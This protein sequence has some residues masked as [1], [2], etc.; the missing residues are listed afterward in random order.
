MALKQWVL[1]PAVASPGGSPGF[2]PWD[3]I[4]TFLKINPRDEVA[5]EGY[6]LLPRR[7]DVIIAQGFNPGITS[8]RFLKIN[9]RDK[10][11]N[12]KYG[13]IPFLAP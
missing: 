12:E 11:A 9:P 6:G 2:Q 13:L 4:H 3:N 5:N 7:G 10:V 8:T 1:T